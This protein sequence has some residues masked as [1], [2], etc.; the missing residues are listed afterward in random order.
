MK[1]DLNV[2]QQQILQEDDLLLQRCIL[3]FLESALNLENLRSLQHCFSE[4][5]V[6]DLLFKLDNEEFSDLLS[7]S[8]W[9]ERVQ[10]I[11]TNFLNKKSID[12]NVTFDSDKL[13]NREFDEISH[14]LI[15]I[16]AMIKVFNEMV[17]SL[18]KTQMDS[19]HFY[20]LNGLVSASERHIIQQREQ[21][22][23]RRMSGL[24]PDREIENY[25]NEI[26]NLNLDQMRF[27][28]FDKNQD[29]MKLQSELQEKK[30]EIANIRID[31]DKAGKKIRELESIVHNQSEDNIQNLGRIGDLLEEVKSLKIDNK[32]FRDAGADYL[33]QEEKWMSRISEKEAKIGNLTREIVELEKSINVYEI[34][35]KEFSKMGER[36][37]NEKEEF[38]RMREVVVALQK[39]VREKNQMLHYFHYTHHQL[40][41]EKLKLDQYIKLCQI[42]I[43]KLTSTEKHLI[44]E[45]EILKALNQN[46]MQIGGAGG[47]AGANQ[48]YAS[49]P[50]GNGGNMEAQVAQEKLVRLLKD[51]I[52]V[53]FCCCVIWGYLE[54]NF[55]MTC[56]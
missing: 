7:T 11:L 1:E 44:H 25:E 52:R 37:K 45:N 56:I 2:F 13:I 55:E 30:N 46:L 6:A 33:I 29:I 41:V 8:N 27:Q 18:V 21:N 40:E 38:L 4:K 20:Y 50:N 31:L 26:A 53:A 17:Y 35:L 47:G 9:F 32:K 36:Y 3:D 12:I 49:V 23:I 28:N 43:Q 15:D 19:D 34:Q 54:I 14:F 24:E 10:D 42:Q 39:N 16:I 22:R 5:L 48:K 51:N